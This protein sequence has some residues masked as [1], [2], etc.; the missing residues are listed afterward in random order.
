MKKKLLLTILMVF[1]LQSVSEGLDETLK[2]DAFAMVSATKMLNTILLLDTSEAMNNF[3]YSDY[4]RTCADSEQKISKSIILC[5]QGYSQCQIANANMACGSIDCSGMLARCNTLKA[6]KVRLDASC[7]PVNGT[8]S[9]AYPPPDG[10]FNLTQAG[11]YN[12]TT[13]VSG[14]WTTNAAAKKYV[15]P[16]D[17]T[18]PKGSYIIDMCFYNWV[19]D[20]G[21][22]V[23]SG[24]D[25]QYPNK[26][27]TNPG[28]DRRDWDCMTSGNSTTAPDVSGLWLNWK[29]ATAL[30]AIKIIIADEHEFAYTPKVRAGQVQCVERLYK[31]RSSS[32]GTDCYAFDW[33]GVIPSSAVENMVRLNWESSTPV[34]TSQP[35]GTFTAV[36]PDPSPAWVASSAPTPACTTCY[37]ELGTSIPCDSSSMTNYTVGTNPLSM[38]TSVSNKLDCCKVFECVEPRCRDDVTCTNPFDPDSCPG[39]IGAYSQFDQDPLHC[40]VAQ[41]CASGAGGASCS[42]GIYTST[43]ANA[44][45]HG[46]AT[47]SMEVEDNFEMNPAPPLSGVNSYTGATI[48]DPAAGTPFASISFSTTDAATVATAAVVFYYGC[49]GEAASTAFYG[50]TFGSPASGSTIDIRLDADGY[51]GGI[52]VSGCDQKGYKIRATVT[53]SHDGAHSGS[54]TM[55]MTSFTPQ[56]SYTHKV[57]GKIQV[58]N[59]S[60]EFYIRR[61]LEPIGGVSQIVNEY[62]C[63]TTFY[64]MKTKVVNGGTGNCTPTLGAGCVYPK[65]TVINQDQWGNAKATMCSWLCPDEPIYDDIWKCMDFFEEMDTAARGGPGEANIDCDYVPGNAASLNIYN[66]CQ[67]VNNTWQAGYEHFT[68]CESTPFS[69]NGGTSFTNYQCCVA[70]Y[71]DGQQ[72]GQTSHIGGYQAELI[73]GHDRD[74]AAGNYMLQ[75]FSYSPYNHWFGDHSL[76]NASKTAV[77]S[78]FVSVFQTSDTGRRDNACIYDIVQDLYGEDCDTCGLGCC[79]TNLGNINHC[80]YPSFWVKVSNS[81]GG[82][83]IF[84]SANL[85]GDGLTQFKETIKTLKG[86]GG[87]TLGETL[88]DV[89]R[90]VGGLKS[91]YPN[92]GGNYT[93]FISP[94]ESKP[95]CFDNTVILISGGQPNFDSNTT[96][97]GKD[98]NTTPPSPAPT[99]QYKPYKEEVAPP[100]GKNGAGDYT[101]DNAYSNGT[102]DNNSPY[103]VANWYITSLVDRNDSTSGVA[104]FVTQNDAYHSDPLCRAGVPENDYRFGFAAAPSPCAPGT[105]TSGLNVINRIHTVAIGQWALAPLYL[106]E[107]GTNETGYL[108]K[109][110]LEDAALP[111]GGTSPGKFYEL[112]AGTPGANQFNNLTDLFNQ[113]A[114]VFSGI[115][116]VGIPHFTAALIQVNGGDGT[117]DTNEAYVPVAVPINNSISRFW[118]GNIRQYK[119]NDASSGVPC[120]IDTTTT[121]PTG[122]CVDSVSWSNKTDLTSD[123]FGT[124]N[125]GSI[126]NSSEFP[127]IQFKKSLGGG[128]AEKMANSLTACA[129]AVG[130]EMDCYQTNTSRNIYYEAPGAAV[131]SALNNL[132]AL[133]TDATLQTY[134]GLSDAKD[135]KR[136]ISYIYGYDTFGDLSS[137][138]TLGRGNRTIIVQD[139]FAPEGVSSPI[140]LKTSILGAIIHSEPIT[141]RYG[142]SAADTRIIAGANDGLLHAFDGTGAERWA[143]MPSKIMPYLS[144]ILSSADGIMLNSSIDGPAALMHFDTNLDGIINNGEKAYVIFGYR[145]GIPSGSYYTVLD[146]SLNAAP[147]F[148]QHIQ[149]SGQSW[150]K[151]LVFSVGGT[152]HVAFG[153]G[154]DPCY[155]NTTPSGCTLPASPAAWSNTANYKKN[156]WVRYLGLDYQARQNNHGHVPGL[157]SL[158]Y[159]RLGTYP[160]ITDIGAGIYVYQFDGSK[161]G[162]GV[163]HQFTKT[164]HSDDK[165][166][167]WMVSPVVAE[168]KAINTKENE[169]LKDDTELLYFADLSGTIFRIKVDGWDIKRVYKTRAD[170][171]KNNMNFADG[172]RTYHTFAQYPPYDPNYFKEEDLNGK[173]YVPIPIITGNL[174]NPKATGE[175]YELVGFYDKFLQSD[176]DDINPY[177]YATF[178]TNFTETTAFNASPATNTQSGWYVNL[179]FAYGGGSAAGNKLEKGIMQPLLAYS[180]EYNSYSVLVTTYVPDTSGTDCKNSGESRL[181]CKNLDGGD[182]IKTDPRYECC[183]EEEA[184]LIGQGLSAAPK[185]IYSGSGADQVAV[186]GGQDPADI[187]ILGAAAAPLTKSVKILKWYEMY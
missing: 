145:R 136:I 137:D 4:I 183:N 181:R 166:A 25:S 19:N 186:T 184:P 35:C 67:G 72:N 109:S 169:T 161:F 187:S 96:M 176:L 37:N 168:G 124:G 3:A 38:S 113:F 56:L 170:G 141:L 69:S 159:W 60:K 61:A 98:F 36:N 34:G 92:Y 185:M 111:T 149:I 101:G 24:T 76:V 73:K 135:A 175:K 177:P 7:D 99:G 88:Y 106:G 172:I 156:D 117:P 82:K 173:Y 81:N 79:T 102:L 75:D 142:T 30:D 28:I 1:V 153:G 115:K 162:P 16:W 21:G 180:Y 103:Y 178:N 51:P 152:W 140:N 125:L 84:D 78:S 44:T 47:V 167:A 65:H 80:D 59:P 49:I 52:A 127:F 147:K 23:L 95:A 57:D 90:Y 29:Y 86:K 70:G 31:P 164:T 64:S 148:V 120:N 54:V 17:P 105:D 134:F 104:K 128:V 160:A 118:F 18:A 110:I 63:K 5:D 122:K 182:A 138:K 154:Y 89:W 12:G 6:T 91:A 33:K 62:E 43:P 8:I 48:I 107:V 157:L 163:D 83:L 2:D 26:P 42:S 71:Q 46:T 155:D 22:D 165:E 129:K 20:S 158:F 100:R 108:D 53:V 27:I 97:D 50:K 144:F 130:S 132:K 131:G 85:S 151:P 121:S 146:V 9:K 87:A 126:S 39:G 15:G 93:N 150:A 174:P 116:S 143:Y 139:P 32:A 74:T 58:L 14:D 66:C 11:C 55:N 45:G 133:T 123:C 179:N 112:T 13:A 68:A 41:T 171:S 40:C 114:T 77:A 94:I 10:C 119:I